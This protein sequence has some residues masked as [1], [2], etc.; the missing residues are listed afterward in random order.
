[1]ACFVIENWIARLE[2]RLKCT[3]NG[4]KKNFTF[5]SHL[6]ILEPS[7]ID[8]GAKVGTHALAFSRFVAPNGCVIAIDPQEEAYNLLVLNIVL[9][10]VTHVRCL[11]RL[12]ER[13]DGCSICSG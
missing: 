9:N 4:R 3:V 12:G 6:S 10:G 2:H 1:M 8:V 7:F 5:F 13:G 11:R